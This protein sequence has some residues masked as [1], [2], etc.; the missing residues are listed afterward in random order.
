MELDNEDILLGMTIASII[1]GIGISMFFIP[2][3]TGY[4]AVVLAIGMMT[5]AL[6][7]TARPKVIERVRTVVARSQPQQTQPAPITPPV[8]VIPATVTP[9]QVSDE[10]RGQEAQKTSPEERPKTEETTQP[11]SVEGAPQEREEEVPV[12]TPA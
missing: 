10:N 12:T 4:G 8:I 9:P 1:L 6:M 5:L 11:E 3:Y 2:S 7:I